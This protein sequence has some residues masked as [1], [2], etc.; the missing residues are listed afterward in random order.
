MKPDISVVIS[1][2]ERVKKLKRAI[3]SVF[4]QT[5]DNWEIVIVDDASDDKGK[6]QRYCEKIIG[7]YADKI[8]YIRLETNH[9]NHGKP[10][11]VG[12][13]HARA[14]WIAFLDD[15]NDYL[16][17]H[18]QALWVEAKKH[19]QI[20]LLYGDRWVIDESGQNEKRKGISSDFDPV[21][22]AQQNFIDTSDVLVKK[23]VLMEVNGWDEELP[24]FADWNLW[25][26]LAKA[27]KVFGHVPKLITNY[28]MH[29][30]MNQIKKRAEEGK[31]GGF[32]PQ[33]GLILPTFDP[34][35]VEIEANQATFK[36]RPPLKVAFYTLT[37]DRLEY[38]K[39][40]FETL[41]ENA[42]YK[43]D[44]FVVDNGSSDETPEW[45]K[46]NK[47]KY[48]IKELILN[49]KN[50]GISKGSNQALDVIGDDYDI[51]IKID[52]DCR[53]ESEDV[54]AT[55]VDVFKRSRDIILSPT[56]EGLI[57]SPGGVPRV[58]HIYIG[59]RL[60]GLTTHLGGIFVAAHKSAY[61]D[62]RWEENDFLHGMQ[63]AIFSQS[64][65][66]RGFALAYY[67]DL[68]VEHID[69]TD[70]QKKKYEAYFERRKKEK[71]TKY[72]KPKHD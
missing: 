68:R 44:H 24:K 57:D 34:S 40:M 43:Y 62:F 16:K 63:D 67:E 19:P 11:N 66:K 10:K 35:D 9:G 65:A 20:D 23:E 52:N 25:V 18:L 31:P 8:Q 36:K 28:R 49:E 72:E 51:I 56:V 14:D 5:F 29:E 58:R 42:G 33:T 54:L 15:D 38:T 3:Q 17:D 45:L 70:G 69:S 55:L 12:I 39:Q 64:C 60:L 6:T 71:I 21:R 27:R 48:N 13:K 61:K 46:E 37:Y 30:R 53:V 4:D 2:H 1:T 22:L 50:V 41:S 47:K 59:N 7:K 26:R 32:N